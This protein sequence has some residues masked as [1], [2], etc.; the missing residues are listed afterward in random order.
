MVKETQ[1]KIKSLTSVR[2]DV[3]RGLKDM[4]SDELVCSKLSFGENAEGFR[5]ELYRGKV[6]FWVDLMRF[7]GQLDLL[8][9]YSIMFLIPPNW[10][11]DE[12]LKLY[13]YLLTLNEFSQSWDTKFF[14]KGEA[15]AL[16]ASR[17]G[18]EVN[19]ETVRFLVDSFSRFAQ[20]LSENIEKEFGDIL[21][22]FVDQPENE[23]NENPQ[24]AERK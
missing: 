7:G 8:V 18:D 23:E 12:K 3:S 1:K 9:A 20:N 14:L 17:A 5:W 19:R 2:D 21:R 15:V 13:Q 11:N 10:G 22:L 6:P 4:S 24:K 16:C